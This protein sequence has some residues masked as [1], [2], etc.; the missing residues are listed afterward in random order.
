MYQKET[1]DLVA[2]SE[3]VAAETRELANLEDGGLPINLDKVS[4]LIDAGD[5]LKQQRLEMRRQLGI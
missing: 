3:W 2:L 1:V 5:F 4:E